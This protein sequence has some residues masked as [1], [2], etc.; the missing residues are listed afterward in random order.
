M[1]AVRFDGRCAVRA[2]VPTTLR[3]GPHVVGSITSM[4][5]GPAGSAREW[6][7]RRSHH[8]GPPT[9]THPQERGVQ[10]R[11]PNGRA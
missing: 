9:T 5:A 1:H 7:G 11:R 4:V 6:G 3:G 2:Q 10:Y 8:M